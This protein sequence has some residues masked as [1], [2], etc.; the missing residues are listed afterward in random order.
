MDAHFFDEEQLLNLENDDVG[1]EVDAEDVELEGIDVATWEKKN[2]LCVV[3]QEHRL[4]VR[5]QHHDSQLA[6][7]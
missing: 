2:G 3:L 6:G 1:E 7:H 4:E 5:R